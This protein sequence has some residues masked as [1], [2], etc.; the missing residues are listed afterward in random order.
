M[1]LSDFGVSSRLDGTAAMAKTWVGTVSYMSV[2]SVFQLEPIST[3]ESKPE[4]IS[5]APYAYEAD[6]WSLGLTIVELATQRYP[7]PPPGV[8]TK[9]GFWE[10][11]GLE[12]NKSICLCFARLHRQ[13]TCANSTRVAVFY[14][15]V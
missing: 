9:L 1:K 2:C 13:G 5:G 11:L 6:I 14:R 3:W 7:Y 4:R 12:T 15:D 10:L 8:N